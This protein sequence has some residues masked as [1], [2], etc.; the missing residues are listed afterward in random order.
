[1]GAGDSFDFRQ[2][3]KLQEQLKKMQGET[4]ALLEECVRELAQR[5]LAKV[6][7]RTPVGKAPKIK[8]AET[9]KFK[10]ES[11]KSKSFLTKEGARFK[12]YWAGYQGGTLRRSWQVGAIQRVG[13]CFQIEVINPTEYAS[14]VEYGHRQ[15]PNRYVPA[16]G[17]R[18][19]KA[20]V[21]GTFMLTISE[22]QIK[23]IAPALVEKKTVEYLRRC[24][25]GS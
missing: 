7:K 11:G 23:Q 17:K 5:L 14:Y 19:K 8:G 9:A 25:D 2:L 20:W 16:L 13:D 21:P 6:M 22:K 3:E 10:G 4:D 12:K 15:M 18:L 24:F 1:M